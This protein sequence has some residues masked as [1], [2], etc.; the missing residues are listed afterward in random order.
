MSIPINS[1]KKAPDL[2]SVGGDSSAVSAVSMPTTT[3]TNRF[4][5]EAEGHERRRQ[6]P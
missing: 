6:Q 3:A 4:F 1:R 5:S 2:S